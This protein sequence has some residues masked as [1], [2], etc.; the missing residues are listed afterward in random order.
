V[1]PETGRRGYAGAAVTAGRTR[2]ALSLGVAFCVATVG[3]LGLAIRLSSIRTSL[4]LDE[5]S[6]LWAVEAGFGD[7]LRRV[8][9][10]MGQSPFYY[11]FAWASI[12]LFGESEVALRLPS[13]LAVAGASVAIG[14][15]ARELGGRAAAAWAAGLFWLSYTAIWDSLDA[16]PYG[17]ALLFAALAVLGF[18]RVCATSRARDRALWIVGAAGLVWA[19]YIFAPLLGG[20][21]AAYVFRPALRARYPVTRAIGDLGVISLLVL[22]AAVQLATMMRA[23]QAQTWMFRSSPLGVLGLIAPFALAAWFPVRPKRTDGEA[24]VRIGLSMGIAAQFAALALVTAAGANLLDPRYGGVVVVSVA[25]LA[26]DTVAR[27]KRAEALAPLIV[28]AAVTTLTLAATRQVVGSLSGA[29]FQE[30]RE[31]VDALRPEVGRADRAPVL[32][33]SGN[34]EDDL[35]QAGVVQ[36]PATLAPLRSPGQTQPAWNVALLTYRWNSDARAQY[37]ET[38]LSRRLEA[39]PVIFL[40]CLSS[41]E[42]GANGYCGNVVSWIGS[43]WPGRFQARSLGTFRSLTV[44]RFDRRP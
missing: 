18:I 32:Y 24:A 5:F 23:P 7:V 13:L 3:V 27:L 2:P 10:V 38:Q 44:M 16:R 4:W 8:P 36:W 14:Y 30:W 1:S 17:L 41:A 25:V 34:A 19:H 11:V 21:A 26:G 9:T 42:P 20:L 39:E 15:A 31:A 35:G 40:L 37:F 28:Y 33:R 43:T 29:G 12:H 22:P 6:T